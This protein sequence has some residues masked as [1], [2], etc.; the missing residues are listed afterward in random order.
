MTVRH[1][2]IHG[3]N[4]E[5]G[6]RLGE[7]AMK[8]LG[9]SPADFAAIPLFV[10]ARRQYFQR[11]YPIHWQRVRGLASAFGLDSDDDRYDLSGVIYNIHR[12]PRGRFPYAAV[13][14]G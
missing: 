2:A 13:A 11:H 4:F 3:T 8:R 6:Q 9:K 7:L 12:Q 14:G 1:L 10:R 5:I